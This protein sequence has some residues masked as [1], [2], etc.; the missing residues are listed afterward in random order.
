MLNQRF[1]DAHGPIESYCAIPG[2]GIPGKG[3][4]THHQEI[5]GK[6]QAPCHLQGNRHST[7]GHREKE[8]VRGS[9][10]CQHRGQNFACM[11]S[12]AKD[13]GSVTVFRKLD[14]VRDHIVLHEPFPK[15]DSDLHF[16]RNLRCSLSGRLTFSP[17]DDKP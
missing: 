16:E 2:L 15:R 1:V 6:V 11:A 3:D 8:G 7:G 9:I 14:E 5:H 17:L 10:G 13:P 12:V 4:L